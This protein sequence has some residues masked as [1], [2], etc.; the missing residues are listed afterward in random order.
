M[1]R[2][3]KDSEELTSKLQEEVQIYRIAKTKS[4]EELR[5]LRKDI[6]D[7]K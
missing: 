7:L 3:C 6:E 5:E 2:T 4:D 1:Q